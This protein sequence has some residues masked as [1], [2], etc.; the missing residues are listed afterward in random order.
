M[1]SLTVEL[2]PENRPQHPVILIYTLF[3]NHSNVPYTSN[4]MPAYCYFPLSSEPGTIRL[5]RIMPHQDETADIQC[6]LFEYPLQSSRSTHLYEAL[7][8]VWGDSD[9][10]LPILV[11]GKSFNVT[12]NLHAALLQLRNHSIERILWIDAICI[13]QDNQAEK[14]HQIQYMAN[15][16]GQ[17]NRVL[18]WL[19]EAADDSD[20]VFDVMRH[21]RNKEDITVLGMQR[22]ELAALALLQ[23]S[24]F[25]RIWVRQ[26]I[27]PSIFT[28]RWPM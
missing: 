22:L 28:K 17:A 12:V 20:L 6:E 3:Q 2:P 21:V 7:S 15:I 8:Y 23:R 18:V 9:Q 5:L 14:E 19:G 24:W 27:L 13:D 10:T 26:Q 25:Q 11:H 16:Y 1:T 4:A